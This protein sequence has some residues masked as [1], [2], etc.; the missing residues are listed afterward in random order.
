[1]ALPA[2]NAKKHGDAEA[3][4]KAMDRANTRPKTRTATEGQTAEA[5]AFET[6]ARIPRSPA[7]LDPPRA[8][9][10]PKPTTEID[11]R[12]D[13][14]TPTRAPPF[15]LEEY[16]D[17]ES[18][19]SSNDSSAPDDG[20]D[21]ILDELHT[22][23]TI[24]QT[25]A[26]FEDKG[27]EGN[28]TQRIKWAMELA[29]RDQE[30]YKSARK[31]IESMAAEIEELKEAVKAMERK[32]PTVERDIQEIKAM[33]QGT[34]SPSTARTYAQAAA[35]PLPPRAQAQA[36]AQDISYQIARREQVEKQRRH[37]EKTEVSINLRT[38][39]QSFVKDIEALSSSAV[40]DS[41]EKAANAWLQEKGEHPIK[42][43]AVRKLGQTVRI[44]CNSEV[45][46]NR[47][48]TLQWE[49]VLG[50]ATLLLPTYGIVIHGASKWAVNDPSQLETLEDVNRLPKGSIVAVK[51]LLKNPRNPESPT[52]S[53]VVAL[54]NAQ[55][56]NR[57]LT[58]GIYVGNRFH[59]PRRY[60]PQCQV[61][62]CFNCQG[63]G[64]KARDCTRPPRCGRCG[65]AHETKSC[66]EIG[67]KCAQCQGSHHAWH[68]S[69]PE[70][71]KEAARMKTLREM[72]PVTFCDG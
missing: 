70:R 34:A 51:P 52:L 68:G 39:N 57:F 15:Q 46:A 63:Y 27:M 32:R 50:G 58:H 35:T 9:P 23:A 30:K 66:K 1:M 29:S 37:R 54:A 71:A 60:M 12:P 28:A 72:V 5:Q 36:Q 40:A 64:H 6:R 16:S 13:P 48:K 11:T 24:M 56:A 26:K 67:A 8:P 4:P 69:C 18:E 19:H 38:A 47:L 10:R 59:K 53:V 21:S 7:K 61:T 62:Q 14:E 44:A 33:L 25:M 20:G 17:A 45:E 22:I 49:T 65:Q 2:E 31:C 43:A 55:H 3:K 42:I 41:V